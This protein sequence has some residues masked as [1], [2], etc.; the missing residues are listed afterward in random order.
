MKLTKNFTFANNVLVCSYSSRGGAMVACE[1]HN[2]EVAGSSPAPATRKTG[3]PAL[4]WSSGKSL[5][6]ATKF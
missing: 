2:L 4:L 3:S 1:A 6:P 5:A